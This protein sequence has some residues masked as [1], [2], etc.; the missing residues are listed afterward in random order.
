MS[1][2]PP[3]RYTGSRSPSPRQDENR[4][5]SMSIERPQ[6]RQARSP[7]RPAHSKDTRYSL[8]VSG[9]SP[10]V[11]E[12]DL[13]D[14]F[15]KEGKVTESRIVSDPRTY[16][17]RGFGFVGYATEQEQ[18]DAIR[19]LDDSNLQ[20]RAIRVE[21]AK[22][23]RPRTPTPGSYR[24]TKPLMDRDGPPRGRDPYYSRDTY[25]GPPRDSYYRDPPYRDPPPF[26]SDSYSR[27]TGRYRQRSR[28]PRGR[29][30]D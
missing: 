17:S 23:A 6:R 22:R 18:D 30:Y 29:Y 19:Y 10:K 3:P 15:N 16:E 9:L 28:S 21:K 1:A 27:D 2:S 25:R 26:R 8:Y 24:G 13:Y 12:D 7:T 4:P 5:R 14:H 11:T 20:G